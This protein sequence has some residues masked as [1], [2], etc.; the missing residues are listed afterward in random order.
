MCEVNGVSSLSNRQVTFFDS[1]RIAL[2]LSALA[3]GL[4]VCTAVRCS[5][6]LSMSLSVRPGLMDCWILR[7]SASN[8]LRRAGDMCRCIIISLITILYINSKHQFVY[9]VQML[10]P[11]AVR[12]LQSFQY[13]NHS[14]N[15][16]HDQENR[17]RW[18]SV[19]SQRPCCCWPCR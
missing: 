17:S 5:K 10:T 18:S 15:E 1:S 13:T 11:G 4:S 19:V 7:L 3:F 8:L 12:R 2:L 16:H 14:R 9:S 6:M